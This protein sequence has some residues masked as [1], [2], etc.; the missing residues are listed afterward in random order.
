MSSTPRTA[1]RQH[2]RH[3]AWLLLV[4]HGVIGCGAMAS[5]LAFF[6]AR[7]TTGPSMTVVYAYADRHTW[8]AVWA[9]M[10]LLSLL[11]LSDERIADIALI[12]L[13]GASAAWSVALAW[14]LLGPVLENG[15]L[16]KVFNALAFIPWLQISIAVLLVGRAHGRR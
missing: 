10:A 12:L 1:N 5:A 3:R 14:P 2:T 9:A 13:A 16:P 4:V 6:P 7:W 8:A 11:A 15:Q